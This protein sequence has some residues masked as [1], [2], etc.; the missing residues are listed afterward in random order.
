[1]F[2][3]FFYYAIFIIVIVVG[4]EVNDFVLKQ[5]NHGLP[6]DDD[7]IYIIRPVTIEISFCDNYFI[8][9]I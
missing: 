9:Y 8:L 1:M 6:D 2:V 4:V 3:F 7:Y 5:L